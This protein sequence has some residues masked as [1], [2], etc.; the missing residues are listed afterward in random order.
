MSTASLYCRVLLQRLR[1][2]WFNAPPSSGGFLAGPRILRSERLQW[3][4]TSAA[5]RQVSIRNKMW[6]LGV[7]PI[8]RAAPDRSIYRVD[9]VRSEAL[10][11]LPL[12]PKNVAPRRM[13]AKSCK[14]FAIKTCAFKKSSRAS[15]HSYPR[16]LVGL[17][18]RAGASPPS[19]F[20]LNPRPPP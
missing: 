14:T 4:T 16:I 1:E 7:G 2:G 5:N 17:E 18:A 10:E 12:A 3:L 15:A 8:A 20:T 6:S 13:F 11:D 9:T 19:F